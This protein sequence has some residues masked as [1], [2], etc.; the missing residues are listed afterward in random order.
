MPLFCVKPHTSSTSRK[1]SV[2][3]LLHLPCCTCPVAPVM[4]PLLALMHLPCCPLYVTPAHLPWS[5]VSPN[6]STTAPSQPCPQ[7]QATG[8]P[9]PTCPVFCP[10]CPW[11]KKEKNRKVKK[12][13]HPCL[14][15]SHPPC[16]L[17][18]MFAP[19][20]SEPS[21]CHHNCPLQPL[22]LR[23]PEA[24]Y[25]TVLSPAHYAPAH[26]APAHYFC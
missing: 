8:S 3:A 14:L 22:Q 21:P 6:A 10:L 9:I 1:P 12:N 11:P 4:L 13:L 25:L 7:A 17:L 23:L 20:C 18:S 2:S 19:V 5:A 26:F 24:L 16:P 15:H